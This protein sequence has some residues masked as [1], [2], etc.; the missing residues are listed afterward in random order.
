MYPWVLLQIA[1]EYGGSVG[2]AQEDNGRPLYRWT[3][4]GHRAVEALERL[5]PWLV[6][7][8][9]QASLVLQARGT[10]AGRVRDGIVAQVAALK[11]WDYEL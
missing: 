6:V 3:V 11:H 5:L 7:K 10:P 2:E 9:A 8:Q 4:S 1:D